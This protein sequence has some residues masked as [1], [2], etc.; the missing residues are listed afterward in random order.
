MKPTLTEMWSLPLIQCTKG[1]ICGLAYHAGVNNDT[2]CAGVKSSCTK[3]RANTSTKNKPAR[4]S[5]KRKMGSLK[6][7]RERPL[8]LT[9]HTNI[10]VGPRVHA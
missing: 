1:F 3:T 8:W 5:V 7:K 2:R 10:Y 4:S 6:L 9:C